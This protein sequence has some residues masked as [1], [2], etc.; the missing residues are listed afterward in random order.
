MRSQI[1]KNMPIIRYESAKISNKYVF[2]QANLTREESFYNHHILWRLHLKDE[3]QQQIQRK[4]F[5][6]PNYNLKQQLKRKLMI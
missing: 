2:N 6:D 1:R 5:K 3:C 4:N